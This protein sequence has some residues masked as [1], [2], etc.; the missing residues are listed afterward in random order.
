MVHEVFASNCGNCSCTKAELFVVLRG[1][2]IACNGGHRKVQLKVD[3]DVVVRMLLE[4]VP[5]HS[6]Y[7]HHI[8]RC[9]ALIHGHE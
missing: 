7:I 4:E 6:P 9:K 1:L 5:P 3:S 2:A 8:H